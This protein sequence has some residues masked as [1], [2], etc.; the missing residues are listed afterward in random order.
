[1]QERCVMEMQ[2]VEQDVKELSA[3]AAVAEERV[4]GV[5]PLQNR[6]AV[7]QRLLRLVVCSHTATQQYTKLNIIRIHG[8]G[9]VAR[10]TS[11]HET[12]GCRCPER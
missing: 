3:D 9:N 8:T 2:Y 10:R 11:S 5:V 6:V 4:D 1:M 7:C 12:S